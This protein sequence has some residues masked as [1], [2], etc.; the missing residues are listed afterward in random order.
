MA[1]EFITQAPRVQKIALGVIA[2][3]IIGA[4]GYFLLL[5]PR[6]AEVAQLRNRNAA[7]QAEVARNRALAAR[8]AGF[9]KEAA[10]LR[11]RLDAARA[12]LPV[13]KEVPRLYRQ[14]SNL[15][16][17][18]GLAVSLFQPKDPKPKDVYDEVPIVLNA[19]AGYHQLGKFLERVAKLPRIVTLNEFKLVGIQRPTG[20]LRAEL[21]LAT[22]VFRPEGAPPP[23][24]SPGVKR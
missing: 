20:S 8:L 13:E 16:I 1:L 18:S 23:P 2:L 17:Q 19:E 6:M 24:P 22:Y 15:A 21:N 11:L 12:R 10:A 5:S 4:G 14:I 7:L 9:R 3:A